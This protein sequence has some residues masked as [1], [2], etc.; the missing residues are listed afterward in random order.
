MERGAL[1]PAFPD[2]RVQSDTVLVVAG[3]GY[4][5]GATLLN[6]YIR[7]RAETRK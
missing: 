2:T 6:V 4:V 5:L 7:R 3:V 1:R